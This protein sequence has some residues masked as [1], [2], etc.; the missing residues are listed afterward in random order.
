MTSNGQWRERAARARALRRL[1]R[2]DGVSQRV[3]TAL[4][5]SL[6]SAAV[7]AGGEVCRGGEPARLVYLVSAGELANG[8]PYCGEEA[9]NGEATYRRTVL[10]AT[11]TQLW[12]LQTDD[13][14]GLLPAARGGSDAGIGVELREVSQQIGRRRLLHRVSFSVRPGELMAIVGES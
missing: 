7:P 14:A 13:V 5:G 8:L 3:V 10:A 2:L 12:T 11:A 4:A 9:L 6:G 1:S